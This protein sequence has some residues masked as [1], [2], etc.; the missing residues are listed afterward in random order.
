MP[1]NLQ[2][3]EAVIGEVKAVE[4]EENEVLAT[5][6][7][8]VEEIKGKLNIISEL[9]T[10]AETLGQKVEQS[11]GRI[12]GGKHRPKRARKTKKSQKKN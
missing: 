2:Q 4:Q 5:I 3:P 12:R 9:C 8:N 1:D 10:K 11:L 6:H 7:R